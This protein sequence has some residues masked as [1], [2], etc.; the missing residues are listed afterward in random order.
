VLGGEYDQSLRIPLRR[1]PVA[2][3]NKKK[4]APRGGPKK[5]QGRTYN[6]EKRSAR[7]N[8]KFNG[9]KIKNIKN[10]KGLADS[11]IGDR[12][13]GG[14][15]TPEPRG[16]EQN[17]SGGWGFEVKKKSTFGIDVATLTGFGGKRSGRAQGKEKPEMSVRRP[18]VS[19]RENWVQRRA[20]HKAQGKS[21]PDR[22]EK[23]GCQRRIWVEHVTKES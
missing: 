9:V 18:N 17:G 1:V 10:S 15:K 14:E 2:Y 3:T 12:L 6:G 11:T 23:R 16:R 5:T 19:R 7:I 21:K 22:W 13:G 8:K 20:N 4:S